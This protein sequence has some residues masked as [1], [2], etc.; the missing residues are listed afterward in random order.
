[1]DFSLPAARVVRTLTELVARHG[2]PT[3]L[4]VDNGPK[5]ISQALPDWYGMQN[6]D[7]QWVQPASP[8]QNAYVER[9]NGS[10]R[11]ELLDGYWLLLCQPA[12]SARTLPALA[13]RIQP[14]AAP[15]GA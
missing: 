10:F 14:S 15:P 1:M 3:R 2:L 9:F 13:V 5:L 4:R 12:A 6:I 7:L 11:R 8:T